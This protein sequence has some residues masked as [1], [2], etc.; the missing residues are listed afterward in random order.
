MC[1]ILNRYIYIR[2]FQY[3]VGFALVLLAQFIGS[4]CL[5]VCSHLSLDWGCSRNCYINLLNPPCPGQVSSLEWSPADRLTMKRSSLFVLKFTMEFRS[6]VL[7]A[8]DPMTSMAQKKTGRFPWNSSSWPGQW[9]EL[10][11]SIHHFQDLALDMEGEATL[12]WAPDSF[13]AR[14]MAK[15]RTWSIGSADGA[16]QAGVCWFMGPHLNIIISIIHYS[17][18]LL[19]W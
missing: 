8:H 17:L 6:L 9:L 3:H 15:N 1:I 16:P 4:I 7:W 11:P 13:E 19:G 2:I 10:L 12:A 14:D 18:F 5:F